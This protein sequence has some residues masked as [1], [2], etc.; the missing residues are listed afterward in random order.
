[1][2]ALSLLNI[3]GKEIDSIKLDKSV[4]DGVVNKDVIY[5]AMVAY[6]A[7]Q[8]TGLAATKT[9]GEVSGG[10]K[11][12]WK[13]KG[14]GRARHGSTRSPI[15]RHG[16]VTF[17]PHPRDYSYVL[18]QKIKTAALKSALNLKVQENSIILLDQA[19]LANP[20]TKQLCGIFDKLKF[21]DKK[22]KNRLFLIEK[23]DKDI[24]VASRN[25]QGLNL[26][27]SSDTNAYE[28]LTARK[29]LI[30]KAALDALVKRLKK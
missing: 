20:K 1:M 18:P 28:V 14:T 27:L 4:F 13:Q 12:P 22:N 24:K 9:R 6:R 10:G 30:T 19:K 7:N 23:M 8:R 29:I 21:V 3:E 17:G 2:E 25:I 5:Q 15:W 11:K 26:S 16:G